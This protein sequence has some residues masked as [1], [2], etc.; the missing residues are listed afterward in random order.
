MGIYKWVLQENVVF[1]HD[2]FK[3]FDGIHYVSLK[4]KPLFTIKGGLLKVYKG[5]A[6]NGASPKIM[7]GTI[8][9]GAWDGPYC[10]ST[11]KQYLYYP[12]LVHDVLYQI[13]FN[14][15]IDVDLKKVDRVF[16]DRSLSQ[17]C[18]NILAKFLARFYYSVLKS[19]SWLWVRIG[20]FFHNGLK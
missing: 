18:D 2:T 9:I 8:S 10:E 11:G 16:L 20:R 3:Y 15:D 7:I 13:L 17:P 4:G 1:Y 6:W 12:T 19:F 14:E 5:Y